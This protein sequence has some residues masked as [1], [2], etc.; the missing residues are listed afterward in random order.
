[1]A[2]RKDSGPGPSPLNDG[3]HS[4]APS[5]VDN[6]LMQK[7]KTQHIYNLCENRMKNVKRV[8]IPY[9]SA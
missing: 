2:W 3:A 8:S 1:M 9:Y 4:V 6:A 7:F 5:I